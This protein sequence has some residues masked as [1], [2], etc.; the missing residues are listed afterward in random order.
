MDVSL[1]GPGSQHAANSRLG[2]LHVAVVGAGRIGTEVVRNLDLMGVGRIDVYEADPRVA[3]P[4]H[5]RHTVHVGDF[6]DELTLSRLRACDF[7]I[8]TV[9]D[10]EARERANQKCLVANVNLVQVWTEESLAVVAIH[11]FGVLDDCACHECGTSRDAA[12]VQLAALTL[13]VGDAGTEAG[14]ADRIATANIAGALAAALTVRVVTGAFGYVA[15]RATLDTATGQGASVELRRD[16]QCTRCGSLQRPVPIVHTRNRWAVSREVELHAP[17]A[18]DQ[19][20]QLSDAIDGLEGR[21]VRV[22]ELIE[23]FQGGPIPAKFALAV[24]DGRVVCLDFEDVKPD[25]PR[26]T[27]GASTEP[28]RAT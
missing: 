10:R 19:P 6:W 2:G 7:A 14:N 15:R 9:D 26:V 5:A 11:P 8:C 13:T 16:P 28:Q 17:G 20:L 1:A 23:R 27:V 12:P 24:C 22:A 25:E 21:Q 4:L 3:D 18:L